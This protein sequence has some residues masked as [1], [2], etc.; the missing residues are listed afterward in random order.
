MTKSNSKQK[1]VKNTQE[2]EMGI[3]PLNSSL[4][5]HCYSLWRETASTRL[6]GKN[7]RCGELGTT[8]LATKNTHCGELKTTRLA[9]KN[10][11]WASDDYYS[12]GEI[13]HS[14][15][16]AMTDRSANRPLFSLKT[17]ILT[18]PILIGNNAY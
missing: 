7:I 12:L 6:A 14:P 8:R 16:R 13:E 11:H 5:E 17:L 4:G 15:W 3:L 2:R 9:T 10:T 18:T 1:R